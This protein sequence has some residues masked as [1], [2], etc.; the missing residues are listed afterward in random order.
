MKTAIYPGSF[1][2]VTLGHLDVI[3]RAAAIFDRVVVCVMVNCDKKYMFTSQE[4]ADFISK[5]TSHL[6]NVQVELSERLL[7]DYA[8]DYEGSV[9]VKGLR[10]SSD[11]EIE[12]QMALINKT[13]NPHLET[14]FLPS[15]KENV[16]LSS[17]AAREMVR[18]RADLSG[19]VPE[20]II[21]DIKNKMYKD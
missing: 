4:R 2:P 14:V 8:K 3:E 16:F 7:A 15:A 10:N 1:D 19:F 9:L 13:A 21:D 5:V 20:A 12:F 18:Y 17:S 11:F 6:P